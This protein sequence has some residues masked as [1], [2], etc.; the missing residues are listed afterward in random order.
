MKF[1]SCAA[2]VFYIATSAWPPT[3]HPWN[4]REMQVRHPDGHVFRISKSLEEPES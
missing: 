4:M 2:S 1:R 3:D